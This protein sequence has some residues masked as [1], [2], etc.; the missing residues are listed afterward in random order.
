M[1]NRKKYENLEQ[2]RSMIEIPKL[3]LR[4]HFN[5]LRNDIDKVYVQ[6]NKNNN[7]DKN[8]EDFYKTW[9]EMIERITLIEKECLATVTKNQLSNEIKK[10]FN[11]KIKTIRE[12][13]YNGENVDSDLLVETNKI[14]KVLFSNKTITLVN[15]NSKYLTNDENDCELSGHEQ[16]QTK[17][18]DDLDY[19]L[20][21]IHNEYIDDQDI[22]AA[23]NK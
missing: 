14:K 16:E 10:E 18:K 11:D 4:Y 12:R 8:Q 22:E 15:T 20:L 5:S 13:I 7:K 21:I 23:M 17:A 1:E 19:K 9:K 6:K 3:Y 2:L